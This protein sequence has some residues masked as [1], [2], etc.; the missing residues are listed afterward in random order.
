MSLVSHAENMRNTH[1]RSNNTTGATGVF[2]RKDRQKWSVYVTTNGRREW[3]GV[4]ADKSKAVELAAV[5][6]R[7]R[8]FLGV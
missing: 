3:L 5:A 6:R 8:G 2:W 1:R 7:E 4:F